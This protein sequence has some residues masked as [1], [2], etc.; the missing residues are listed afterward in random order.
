MQRSML[1]LDHVSCGPAGSDEDT[2]TVSASFV[3]DFCND[4]YGSGSVMCTEEEKEEGEF[5]LSFIGEN[6]SLDGEEEAEAEAEKA[7]LSLVDVDGSC[8]LQDN[9]IITQTSIV[10]W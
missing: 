4:E 6:Q 8:G 2:E 3:F 1:I 5:S 9:E 10:V 7:W